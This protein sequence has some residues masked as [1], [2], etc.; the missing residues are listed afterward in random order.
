MRHDPAMTIDASAEPAPPTPDQ[1]VKR[2]QGIARAIFAAA[3]FALGAWT[4]R[5]FLA[6]LA[7]AA[8]I[9]I[10]T[11]PL[12]RRVKQRWPAPL[13]HHL[14]PAL[15]TLA[16]GLV[17]ILPIVIFGIMLSRESQ[18]AFGW[19]EQIRTTGLP[20]PDWVAQL[21][22]VG[23]TV[24]N[25]WRE[26]LESPQSAAALVK[27]LNH[28]DIVAFS[29]SF[30]AQLGRRLLIFAFTLLTLFFL[31]KDGESF[32][33]SLDSLSTRL[34]GPRGNRLRVQIVASV[35]G[36]VDGLVLVGFGEGLV[37]AIAY[38][39]AGVP[40]PTLLGIATAI[41]AIIPFG[42]FVLFSIAAILLIYKGAMISAIVI[43]ALGLAVVAVADHLVRPII[44]GS[45]TR[46]P[47]LW[48]LLGIL[49]GV[50]TWGLLGLFLGPA[51]MTVLMDLW[52]EGTQ[53]AAGL[54]D[55]GMP[56]VVPAGE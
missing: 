15:F 39:I 36:T 22:G 56:T 48:V 10:A 44:I 55:E 40:Q 33:R 47:F 51:I 29:E 38:Y 3:L 25:W 41:G 1:I 26:N 13:R 17:F 42:A 20:V 54:G 49:G 2:R 35:H 9:A 34:F 7:W 19:V 23:S 21:P 31:F 30:G 27:G 52:R 18:V 16:I 12:Y 53:T 24:A 46:L 11:W 32:S 28:G 50:E 8:V 6:A 37:L 14:L 45:A 43:F 5:G 4:L